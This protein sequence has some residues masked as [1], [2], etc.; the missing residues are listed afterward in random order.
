MGWPDAYDELPTSE[1]VGFIDNL[2]LDQYRYQ[3]TP[4]NKYEDFY[5]NLLKNLTGTVVLECPLTSSGCAGLRQALDELK[6]ENS[7]PKK[8]VLVASEA[9]FPMAKIRFQH[10]NSSAEAV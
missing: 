2:E 9:D 6:R 10:N 7:L 3:D 1:L 5:K 8:L 4:A